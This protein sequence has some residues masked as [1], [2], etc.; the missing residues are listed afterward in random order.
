MVPDVDA[1]WSRA[2]E[3]GVPVVAPIEDRSYGLVDFTVADPDG[4]GARFATRLE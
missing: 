1:C 4:F 3:L 2:R